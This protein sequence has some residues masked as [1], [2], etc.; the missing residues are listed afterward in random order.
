MQGLTEKTFQKLFVEA[1]DDAFASLGDSAKQSIYF[2]L[3]TKFKIKRLDILHRLQDFDDGLGKIFGQGAK[4][5]EILIM[6][7]LYQ[8]AKLDRVMRWDEKREF[9][10]VDYVK[11]AEDCFL[12][13]KARTE[14]M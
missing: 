3:E 9:K 11:A 5:L 14:V 6:K 10:F 12:D 8:K 4:F 1:V 7:N 2:H 13:E